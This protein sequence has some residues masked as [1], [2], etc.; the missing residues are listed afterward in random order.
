MVKLI[1]SIGVSDIVA[2]EVIKRKLY[3]LEEKGDTFIVQSD[4]YDYFEEYDTADEAISALY[5]MGSEYYI[6]AM[7]LYGEDNSYSYENVFEDA[8]SGSIY[9]D[10]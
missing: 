3:W 2:D 1:E 9:D 8:N 4:G 6:S 5:E 10:E 7:G